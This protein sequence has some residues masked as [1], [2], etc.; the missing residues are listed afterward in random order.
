MRHG[1]LLGRARQEPPQARLVRDHGPG[2]D[3][4]VLEVDGGRQQGV[5]SLPPGEAAKG[6][7]SGGLAEI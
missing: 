6:I 7:Q 4:G 2:D 1:S 5:P 3:H